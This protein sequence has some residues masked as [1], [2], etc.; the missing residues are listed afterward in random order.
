MNLA[1]IGN[2]SV[3]A[4]KPSGGNVYVYNR[5]SL[6]VTYGL[7]LAILAGVTLQGL[8][9]LW[10]DGVPSQNTF[11]QILVTTRNIQLDKL[12]EGSCLGQGSSAGDWQQARVMFGE[13]G[14]DKGEGCAHHAA[15]GVTDVEEVR[16]LMRTHFYA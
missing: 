3:M 16:P 6:W 10:K 12:V 5:E 2:T 15:F 11:S 14:D 1:N 13:V 9:A 4:L 7:A 8:H